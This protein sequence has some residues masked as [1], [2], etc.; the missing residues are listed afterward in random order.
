MFRGSDGDVGRGEDFIREH[1]RVNRRVSS[2]QRKYTVPCVVERSDFY[3]DCKDFRTIP[4]STRGL[5]LLTE[6]FTF[7]HRRV[8]ARLPRMT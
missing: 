5:L 7:V 2:E 6:T 4:V 3:G 1:R 8:S